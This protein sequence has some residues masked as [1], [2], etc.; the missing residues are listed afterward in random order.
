MSLQRLHLLWIQPVFVSRVFSET[1]KCILVTIAQRG[2]Q[3]CK[4]KVEILV[5]SIGNAV[6]GC[7]TS[8]IRRSTRE[9]TVLSIGVS[10]RLIVV[11]GT[12]PIVVWKSMA[13]LWIRKPRW[14]SVRNS[15]THIRQLI[16]LI[17][18]RWWARLVS[19]AKVKGHDAWRESTTMV[20]DKEEEKFEI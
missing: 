1:S 11:C 10:T 3:S 17:T 16:L 15:A 13:W 20:V 9:A 18:I 14:A 6:D 4:R 5:R 19:R 7:L 2:E 8:T 12:T